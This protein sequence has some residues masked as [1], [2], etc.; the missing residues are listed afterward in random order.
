LIYD[1][2]PHGVLAELKA[3]TPKNEH[4]N[5]TARYHQLLTIDVGEPNLTAQI[6]QVVTLFQLSDNMEHMWKQFEKLKT[7]Q[8]GQLE[9]PFSFD[10]K[11][12]TIDPI[13]TSTL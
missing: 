1:Q 2:L 13:E 8:S 9:L 12:Y 5:R 3:K 11:G 7:R 10:A 6:G 4:G